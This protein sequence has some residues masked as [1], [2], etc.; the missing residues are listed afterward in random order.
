MA[1]EFNVRRVAWG[2]VTFP[3]NTAL[4]TASTLSANVGDTFLPKG[5][6][7]TNIWYRPGGALTN[8][9]AMKDGTINILAGAEAIGTNDRKASEALLAGSA[10]THDVV[11]ASGGAL[12]AGGRLIAN[13]ASSDSDRSAIAADFDVYVEYLYAGGYDAS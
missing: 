6:I 8:M 1:N 11:A 13:F 7:V 9:S 10:L 2:N 12:S 4:N 5:A 3:S